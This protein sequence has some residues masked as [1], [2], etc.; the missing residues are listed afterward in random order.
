MLDRPI[1]S[2]CSGIKTMIGLL[3]KHALGVAKWQFIVTT[4]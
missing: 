2:G 1:G 3:P 4:L